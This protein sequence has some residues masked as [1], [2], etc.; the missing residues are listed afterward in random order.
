MDTTALPAWKDPAS[1]D[2]VT[3]MDQAR[4]AGIQRSDVN[5]QLVGA[6]YLQKH[7]S[8]CWRR[9]AAPLDGNAKSTRR[10]KA[11]KRVLLVLLEGRGEDVAPAAVGDGDKVEIVV[12]G[13]GE[14]GLDAA[15][16]RRRNRPRRQ[17][18]IEMGVVRAV[19]RGIPPADRRLPPLVALRLV[20]HRVLPSGP[21]KRM[22]AGRLR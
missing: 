12:A 10:D 3:R 18:G 6:G 13:G 2:K 9:Q 19:D 16:P 4:E 21:S 22:P 17:P 11:R 5:G 14:H 20:A 1:A 7:S 15:Q 8:R